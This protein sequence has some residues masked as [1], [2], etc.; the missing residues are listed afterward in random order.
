[1]KEAHWIK[2]SIGHCTKRFSGSEVILEMAKLK[3]WAREQCL[4]RTDSAVGM[5]LS[6]RKEIG[7]ATDQSKQCAQDQSKHR[8]DACAKECVGT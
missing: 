1:M 4:L 3:E 8:F 7:W 2:R 5:R 6:W